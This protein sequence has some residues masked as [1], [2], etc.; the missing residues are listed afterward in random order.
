[1]EGSKD[2]HSISEFLNY[3]EIIPRRKSSQDL[4]LYVLGVKG[5]LLPQIWTSP[6]ICWRCSSICKG[7]CGSEDMQ[8]PVEPPRY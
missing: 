5:S 2:S 7:S 1:M 4:M 8:V 3:N 6:E